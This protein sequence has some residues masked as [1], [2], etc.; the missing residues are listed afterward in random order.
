MS[1][2]DFTFIKSDLVMGQF[3]WL[4]SWWVSEFSC[5]RYLYLAIYQ[6]L[7]R[8][9]SRRLLLAQEARHAES[10]WNKCDISDSMNWW[11]LIIVMPWL[12]IY[13][14]IYSFLSFY[15]FCLFAATWKRWPCTIN[16][17][18]YRQWEWRISSSRWHDQELVTCWY[19]WRWPYKLSNGKRIVLLMKI[20]F[21]WK[22][23]YWQNTKQKNKSIQ[24]ST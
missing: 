18:R 14:Y 6:A 2:F 16:S 23:N 13:I 3:N 20:V 19:L 24:N 1:D 21:I 17:A 15:I 4:V 11:R 7:D 9:I 10:Y 8:Q 12:Y 22:E 5:E